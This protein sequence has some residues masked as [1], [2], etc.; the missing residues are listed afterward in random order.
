VVAYRP[1]GR[2]ELADGRSLSAAHAEDLTL[3]VVGTG[4]LACDVEAV[5]AREESV[6]QGLLGAHVDLARLC[7]ADGGESLDAAATR[8]WAAIECLRKA[9]LSH[10]APLAALPSER[11]GWLVFA[12]GDLRIATLVTTVR[13]LPQPMA[14]AILTEG[15]A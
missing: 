4:P 2:P 14:F 6:W 12:S 1:D 11:A 8:V 7:A 10:R 15:R 9:G 5:R 3:C 13:D